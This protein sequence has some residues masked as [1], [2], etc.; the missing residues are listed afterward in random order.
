MVRI[1]NLG[2]RQKE[3]VVRVRRSNDS[4]KRSDK[5]G[6][7]SY[8]VDEPIGLVSPNALWHQPRPA[9]AIM[10]FVDLFVAGEERE[11]PIPPRLNNRVIRIARYQQG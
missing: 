4:R 9:E 6:E 8:G 10:Q 5:H 3:I 1:A 2:Q 11:R 7:A